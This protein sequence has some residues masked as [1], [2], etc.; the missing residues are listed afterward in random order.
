MTGWLSFADQ[1]GV[2]SIGEQ[3]GQVDQY[4]VSRYVLRDVMQM[5]GMALAYT[6]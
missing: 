6:H 3:S 1:M 2:F 5:H 4:C